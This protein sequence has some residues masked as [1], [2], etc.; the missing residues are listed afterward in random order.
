MAP[1]QITDFGAV[2][3]AADLYSVGIVAYEL[4]TGTKP[5]RDKERQKVLEMHLTLEPAPPS[6]HVPG[7]P[8]TLDRLILDL[9]RKRPTERPPSCEDV[10]AR[11]EVLESLV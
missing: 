5:F 3:R 6:A 8:R 11:L 1:E 2:T 7:L 10:L 9:L 4:V